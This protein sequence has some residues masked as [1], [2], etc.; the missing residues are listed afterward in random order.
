VVLAFGV[1]QHKAVFA[2]EAEAA[3]E[4]ATLDI[5]GLAAALAGLEKM[6]RA[7]PPGAARRP[8]RS[9]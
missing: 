2:T 3:M 9:P 6:V 5:E 4:G 8:S 7:R 1:V